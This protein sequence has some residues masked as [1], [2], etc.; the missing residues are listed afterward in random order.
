MTLHQR[1]GTCLY[2]VVLD[3]TTDHSSQSGGGTSMLMLLALLQGLQVRIYCL[4]S[5]SANKRTWVFYIAVSALGTFVIIVL[6]IFGG[7]QYRRW[8][9]PKLRKLRKIQVLEVY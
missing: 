6:I 3:I 4:G 8:Q 9:D 5:I 2:A 7:Y 1:V